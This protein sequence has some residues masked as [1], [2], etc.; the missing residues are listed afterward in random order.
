MGDGYS[1]YEELLEEK[2]RLM[3]G[4]NAGLE[5]IADNA[6]QPQPQFDAEPDPEYT[7]DPVNA[8]PR[9]AGSPVDYSED[10]VPD[11]TPTPQGGGDPSGIVSSVVEPEGS[12][13]SVDLDNPTAVGEYAARPTPGSDPFDDPSVVAQFGQP[14]ERRQQQMA[15]LALKQKASRAAELTSKMLTYQ[16]FG[17]TPQ[18]AEQ[19]AL[20]NQESFDKY[21]LPL[22]KAAGLT[23]DAALNKAG[24]RGVYFDRKAGV[25]K[26][27]AQA[28][29]KN[30]AEFERRHEARLGQALQLSA[31]I[32]NSEIDP[33]KAWNNKG[34]AA[35]AFIGF[36]AGIYRMLQ[37]AQ[38]TPVGGANPVLATL[39]QSIQTDLRAQEANLNKLFKQR[40]NLRQ[41]ETDDQR[42]LQLK[43]ASMAQGAMYRLAG[44][45]AVMKKTLAESVL[46][47]EA[48]AAMLK[49]I[50]AVNKLYLDQ[51]G[52]FIDASM[53]LGALRLKRMGKTGGTGT[54]GPVPTG[55]DKLATQDVFGVVQGDPKTGNLPFRNPKDTVAN[56]DYLAAAGAR[57]EM[58]THLNELARLHRERARAN[59]MLRG[60]RWQARIDALKDQTGSL[61]MNIGRV[62]TKS[63][64]QFTKEER[65]LIAESYAIDAQGVVTGAPE[66]IER[67]ERAMESMALQQV[68]STRSN[69]LVT[70]EQLNSIANQFRIRGGSPGTGQEKEQLP[71]H[72]VLLREKPGTVQG[73]ITLVRDLLSMD[74]TSIDFASN[75]AKGRPSGGEA[76]RVRSKIE[77]HIKEIAKTRPDKALDLKDKLLKWEKD[78]SRSSEDKEDDKTRR[79]VK[80]I[81][82]RIHEGIDYK[83]LFGE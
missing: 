40:A 48:Q 4:P 71:D 30:L 59:R 27:Q 37:V 14:S 5:S 67:L 42:F 45:E 66:K 35:K 54:G 3:G 21:V 1:T 83:D 25:A 49:D 76:G 73:R 39:Q 46:P 70:Q 26:E 18:E 57:Q 23:A 56:R 19:F 44:A 9:S 6:M 61:I 62:M 12:D 58:I 60:K 51:T 34:L 72:E 78:V 29:A 52:K 64:A 11:F 69:V 10:V 33:A 20:L 17:A 41:D 22:Y 7:F 13:F 55:K 47:L 50:A 79:Q 8:Q 15:Q 32:R 63:G 81:Q 43:D 28:V 65:A 38:G 80:A 16:T 82:K 75:P 74:P 53:K 36:G 2:R 68:N 24:A 77:A 31:Q